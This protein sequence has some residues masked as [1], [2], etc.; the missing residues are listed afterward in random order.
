MNDDDLTTLDEAGIE[1]TAVNSEGEEVTYSA[2]FTY[3]SDETGKSYLAYTD[4]SEDEDGNVAVYA[5]TYDPTTFDSDVE[6]G[7]PVEL[8]EIE[9]EAEW[10]MLEDLI[11]E[12]NELQGAY[13]DVDDSSDDEDQDEE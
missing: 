7:V 3:D 10:D 8:T 13:D 12:F 6:E 9:S 5:A 4:D 11:D 1:F 2:L